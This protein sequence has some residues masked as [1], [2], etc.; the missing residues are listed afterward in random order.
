MAGVA[1]VAHCMLNQNSTTNGGALCPGV[2]SPLVE[3]LREQGWRIEQMPCQS[4][5]SPV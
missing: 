2:Y 4:S 5:P 1:F 3:Q